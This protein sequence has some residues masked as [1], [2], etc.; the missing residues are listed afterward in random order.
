[1]IE[2][3]DAPSPLDTLTALIDRSAVEAIKE[4]DGPVVFG[5]HMLDVGEEATGGQ[6]LAGDRLKALVSSGE[7][8]RAA[9]GQKYFTT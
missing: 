8:A 5:H 2:K 7:I 4:A 1:M 6:S 9:T 3:N